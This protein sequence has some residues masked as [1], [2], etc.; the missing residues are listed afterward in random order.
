[1][2]VVDFAEN[3]CGAKLS[4]WQKQHLRFMYDLSRNHDVRI[5]MGK[6]GQVFTYIK[7]KELAQNG[8]TNACK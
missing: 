8:S 2:D 6:N 7:Q 5:V 4:E 1:M 3:I